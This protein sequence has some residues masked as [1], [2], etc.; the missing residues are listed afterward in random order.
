[1][2]KWRADYMEKRTS[3]ALGNGV[4]PGTLPNVRGGELSELNGLCAKCVATAIESV[5]E[6]AKIMRAAWAGVA[7][8]IRDPAQSCAR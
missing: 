8:A 5:G 4:E 6:N 1:M 2:G 7:P 3:A